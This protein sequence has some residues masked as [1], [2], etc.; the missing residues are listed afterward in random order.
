M[1]RI[2]SNKLYDQLMTIVALLTLELKHQ[3]QYEPRARLTLQHTHVLMMHVIPLTCLGRIVGGLQTLCRPLAFR[4]R[5]YM[6][7]VK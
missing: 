1:A 7:V 2:D 5:K 3:S 4:D 6:C